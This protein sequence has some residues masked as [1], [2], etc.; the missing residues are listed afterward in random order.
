[1]TAAAPIVLCRCGHLAQRHNEDGCT[2]DCLCAELVVATAAAPPMPAAFDASVKRSRVVVPRPKRKTLLD[3][4]AERSG[5]DVR[6]P[7]KPVAPPPLVEEPIIDQVVA[8]VTSNAEVVADR[9]RSILA[10]AEASADATT[11][12]LGQQAEQL[13]AT[14][15]ERLER[16]AAR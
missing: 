10:R 1:M 4:A 5:L 13:L 8:I 15:A 3:V 12:R 16:E 2:P 7:P 11:R 6:K 14:V 9:R